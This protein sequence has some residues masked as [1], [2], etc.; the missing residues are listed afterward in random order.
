MMTR[1]QKTMQ[2]MMRTKKMRI[3]LLVLFFIIS[4]SI[5]AIASSKIQRVDAFLRPDFQVFK[6]GKK[7]DVDTVLIY[8]DRSY[9]KLIEIGKLLDVD[10]VWNNDN[11]G[12]YI[13]SRYEGQ[14]EIPIDDV[15]YDDFTIEHVSAYS[16]TYLGR[17][18]PVVSTRIM[19]KLYYRAIDVNVMGVNTAGMVK[20][21][22]T[23][24]G[25][26]FV[27]ESEVQPFWKE[28]PRINYYNQDVAFFETDKDKADVIYNF[29]ENIPMMNALAR[30]EELRDPRYYFPATVYAID[31]L[32]DDEYNILTMEDGELAWYLVKL[33]KSSVDTWFYSEYTRKSIQPYLYRY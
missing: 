6:D 7:V 31:V 24:T 14:P 25:H 29:I 4:A 20:L 21:R 12:I 18:Y 8:E 16:L 3:G 15:V 30:G 13:N 17:D 1:M 9:L 26:L 10:V 5:G 27:E 32:P 23:F 11:K 2:S 28:A 33:R 22:D 19:G